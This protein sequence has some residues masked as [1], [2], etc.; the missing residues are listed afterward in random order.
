MFKRKLPAIHTLRDLAELDGPFPTTNRHVI[1][2]AERF[3][4]SD[5]VIAFLKLFP[6]EEV[7]RS[8]EDFIERCKQ[9][10]LFVREEWRAPIESLRSQEG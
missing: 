4:F 10:E 3:W 8:R 2:A 7:F 5:D 1:L 9:L 6:S